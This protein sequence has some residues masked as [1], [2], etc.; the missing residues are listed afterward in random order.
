MT[1]VLEG[2][3]SIVAAET[4]EEQVIVPGRYVN[5]DLTIAS[6]RNRVRRSVKVH[7]HIRRV[8]REHAVGR[9]PCDSIADDD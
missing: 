5:R 6:L 3:G 8:K 9:G 2:T 7:L 4:H 1:D